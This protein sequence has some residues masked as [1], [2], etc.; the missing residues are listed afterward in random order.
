[1]CVC[2]CVSL[3][4]PRHMRVLFNN[5]F[6]NYRYIFVHVSSSK[7]ASRNVT[8]NLRWEYTRDILSLLVC[9]LCVLFMRC[10]CVFVMCVS[11]MSVHVCVCVVFV[12]VCNCCVCVVCVV[13]V[14]VVVCVSSV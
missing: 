4:T 11:D 8:D 10:M 6:L 13:C 9:V 5:V 12:S 3:F 14:C 7:S 1:M 2:V